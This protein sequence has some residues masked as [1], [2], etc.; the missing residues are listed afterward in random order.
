MLA[1]F[2]PAIGPC[3]A[4]GSFLTVSE[5]TDFSA[6]T[7]A[8]TVVLVFH[9][10]LLVTLA[11]ICFWLCHHTWCSMSVGFE[12]V[13]LAN[14]S[15]TCCAMSEQEVAAK[16]LD[17]EMVAGWP[18]K[19]YDSPSVYWQV[20]VHACCV[21]VGVCEPFAMLRMTLWLLLSGVHTSVS[22]RLSP[23]EQGESHP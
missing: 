18:T 6:S 7:G 19:L 13:E 8:C 10:V 15:S 11:T 23:S 21:H 22:T 3:P 12:I 14:R 5:E 20:L 1:S 9:T 4:A 2:D 17:P 16:P